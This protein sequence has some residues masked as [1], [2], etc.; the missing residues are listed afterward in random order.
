MTGWL[1]FWLV[2][3]LPG[4]AV[5]VARRGSSLSVVEGVGNTVKILESH[6]EERIAADK[7]QRTKLCEGSSGMLAVMSKAQKEA[8]DQEFN[9]KEDLDAVNGKITDMTEVH[10]RAETELS[11]LQ[12]EVADLK[13]KLLAAEQAEAEATSGGVMSLHELDASIAQAALD[14]AERRSRKVAEPKRLK[15]DVSSL[16]QLDRQLGFTVNDRTIPSFLQQKT[17]HVK[18]RLRGLVAAQPVVAAGSTLVLKSD[19][20]AVVGS[21]RAEKRARDEGVEELRRMIEIKTKEL[22]IAQ[23]ETEVGKVRLSLLTNRESQVKLVY[24]G[25]RNFTQ[26]CEQILDKVR[27]V[28]EEQK[29]DSKSFETTMRN[30]TTLLKMAKVY[31]EKADPELFLSGDLRELQQSPSTG[32]GGGLALVQLVQRSRISSTSDA[33]LA[34]AVDAGAATGV[35]GL[36][37]VADL[38]R[39]LINDLHAQ[40]NDD[41]TAKELCDE[42]TLQIENQKQA[43]G[44]AAD[45][46][47]SES[48]ASRLAIKFLQKH[49]DFHEQVREMLKNMS[50]RVAESIEQRNNNLIGTQ[51][52]LDG[53]AQT[54]QTS[55]DELC[56]KCSCEASSGG[57]GARGLSSGCQEAFSTLREAANQ[58]KLLLDETVKEINGNTADDSSSSLLASANNREESLT[59]S[60]AVFI[61]EHQKS[62]EAFAQEKEDIEKQKQNLNKLEAENHRGCSLTKTREEKIA[63]LENEISALKNALAL[64]NADGTMA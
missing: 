46:T 4:Y 25:L 3:S 42:E 30:S 6:R 56:E 64:L 59:I 15:R 10:S 49:H 33:G 38:I 14:D 55:L 40:F 63:S 13:N 50:T 52:I 39:G 51:N 60:L 11:T 35:D 54:L 9:L 47:E 16:R 23:K 45:S 29:A 12:N 34:I 62:V 57:S 44:V 61:A 37:K 18:N 21:E 31:I 41:M 1:T 36:G 19:R 43:L 53:S 28:C 7:S 8:D 58:I 26:D 2:A 5:T 24:V 22:Q 48:K 32:A 17:T 20:K 27:Q